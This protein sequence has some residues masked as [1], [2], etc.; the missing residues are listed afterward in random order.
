MAD[1]KQDDEGN[2]QRDANGNIQAHI[3]NWYIKLW[4]IVI[5]FVSL[6]FWFG[7]V[8]S[9]RM[10]T[11]Q[12][13]TERIQR[14]VEPLNMQLSRIER[15]IE[16]FD[17]RMDAHQSDVGHSVMIERVNQLLT[18]MDHMQKDLAEIKQK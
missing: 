15:K 4:P 10:E 1:V 14:Y 16:L 2:I 9:L 3:K 18:K 11:P 13:K 8:V 5:A 6:I 7:G 17:D 12:Q